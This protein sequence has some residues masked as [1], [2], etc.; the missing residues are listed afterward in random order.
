[1]AKKLFLLWVM[2]A[3]FALP[4]VPCETFRLLNL[5]DTI[6][7]ADLI[8]V[9]TVLDRGRARPVKDFGAGPEGGD[10]EWV[11]VRISQVLKGKPHAD[12]IK[13]NTSEPCGYGLSD[14]GLGTFLFFLKRDKMGLQYR[15]VWANSK[16]VL[17]RGDAGPLP[18]AVIDGRV[19][20]TEEGDWRTI[21]QEMTLEELAE[22]I[23]DD[24]DSE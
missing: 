12:V 24:K 6:Q 9:G 16:E 19:K 17:A 22:K 2:L 20:F 21:D 3:A 7:E 11:T 13:L 18:L 15:R 14:P 10:P 1:M 4:A 5:E 23:S 8:V